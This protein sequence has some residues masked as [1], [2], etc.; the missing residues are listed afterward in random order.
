MLKNQ[1][2]RFYIFLNN[3]TYALADV[4]VKIS[5]VANDNIANA[6]W[7][8]GDLD[9]IQLKNISCEF[10]LD[11]KGR[12]LKR[13]NADDYY[14]P[15][16]D[17]YAGDN[18]FW[19]NPLEDAQLIDII[20]KNQNNVTIYNVTAGTVEEATR[21]G[22]LQ[23]LPDDKG[24]TVTKTDGSI[25][26]KFE[27]LEAGKYTVE[28]VHNE[29]AYYKK[30][31]NSDSFVIY[32]LNVNKTTDDVLV[33]VGQNVTYNITIFN[34]GTQ[35]ISDI[36]VDDLLLDYFKLLS[37][38]TTWLVS[39]ETK[40]ANPDFYA[41]FTQNGDQFVIGNEVQEKSSI[42]GPNEGIVFTLVY[43]ATKEG[44]YKNLI[45]V[46]SESP[47]TIVV[48]SDN[49]TV[50]VPVTLNVTKKANETVVAN[51]TL[52]DYTILVNNTSLVNITVFNMTIIRDSIIYYVDSQET[53]IE[54][55]GTNSFIVYGIGAT[56]TVEGNAA[57]FKAGSGYS[58]SYMMHNA[59]GTNVTYFAERDEITYFFNN[60]D[61]IPDNI[62]K[63]YETY[64]VNA[65]NVTVVDKLS[66]G[67]DYVD[68]T[69]T[70]GASLKL[71][72]DKKTLT[73]T[74]DSLKDSIELHVT[75][76][77]NTEVT[78]KNLTNNVTANCNENKTPVNY[79]ANVTVE[80]VILEVV[81]DTEF[82]MVANNTQ[83]NY[84]ILV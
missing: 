58:L 75:A 4:T 51:N 60:V 79:T 68:A 42:L 18:K 5:L 83:V 80:L 35:N 13:F 8:D 32:N 31:G 65:T 77:V 37:Y 63:S 72:D 76:R 1:N 50:V 49:D 57:T 52:V 20:I 33:A 24:L 19:Q 40:A 2:H 7:N 73:W 11:S 28:A 41:D 23:A 62:V 64:A 27:N 3:R 47:E 84:T 70:A 55:S 38:S 34:N 39:S 36:A 46:H 56:C 10:S 17:S 16:G 29:D 22:I 48:N 15:A 81:K 43:N 66:E 45:E 69:N 61:L 12:E 21:K 54:I 74:V 78:G 53:P 26:I 9:T 71:S 67:L 25:T 30:V 59:D 44:K 6:I 14:A 82:E